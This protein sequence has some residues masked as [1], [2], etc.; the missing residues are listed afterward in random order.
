MCGFEGYKEDLCDLYVPAKLLH[1]PDFTS[2]PFDSWGRIDNTLL[3]FQLLVGASCSTIAFFHTMS[4]Q[5]IDI[6]NIS[7]E[8]P[9]LNETQLSSQPI[10]SPSS[11]KDSHFVPS[12]SSPSNENCA[13]SVVKHEQ[14]IDGALLPSFLPP[15]G[16][17]YIKKIYPQPVLKNEEAVANTE[18]F[19]D[20]LIKF[21]AAISNEFMIPTI[22]GKE[23][24]LRLLYMEVTSR[25]GLKQVIEERKW[26]KITALFNFPPTATNTSFVLSEYYIS[27]LHHY[28]Q[29]YF[30]GARG[31]LIPPPQT[32]LPAPSTV[33]PPLDEVQPLIRRKKRRA[34]IHLSEVNPASFLGHP[35]TGVIYGKFE[36]GYLV[37]VVVG[38]EKLSGVLYQVPTEQFAEVPSYLNN[39][40][41]ALGVRPCSRRRRKNE[42]KK[43]DPDHPKQNRNGYNFFFAEHYKQLKA[44]HPGKDREITK[45]IGDS[46]K[47]LKEEEKWVYQE[48]ALK[49]KERYRSEI[50]EY[51]KAKIAVPLHRSVDCLKLRNNQHGQ[52]FEQNRH[53][54]TNYA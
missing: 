44:L 28:E 24:D 33:N 47:N 54:M 29:V 43:K 1:I 8:E 15:Q 5:P 36:H 14:A 42:I 25:G 9:I 50:Q 18:V 32:A 23:L 48:L 17:T 39:G 35:V 7:Q 52:Q 41:A 10:P 13:Q 3:L 19:L 34:S 51:R 11:P 49:D 4:H 26:K 21:H 31:H 38:S 37:T 27:L 20:T 46:W 40:D 45:M 6:E 30:F 53:A 2:T 22:G 16:A 12:S